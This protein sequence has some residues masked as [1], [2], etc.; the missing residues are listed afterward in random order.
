MKPTNERIKSLGLD[1][2]KLNN[3]GDTHY[4]IAVTSGVD[5]VFEDDGTNSLIVTYARGLGG[6]LLGKVKCWDDIQEL[7]CDVVVQLRYAVSC[8]EDALKG[9][10]K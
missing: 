10:S 4:W 8:A 7:V 3:L 5:V 1:P 6:G 2:D 9:L